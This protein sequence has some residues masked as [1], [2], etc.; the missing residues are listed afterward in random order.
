MNV[1]TTKWLLMA[2]L[3]GGLSMTVSSCK[4]D[5]DEPTPEPH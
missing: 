2:A 3:F 4:D 1:K 5:N